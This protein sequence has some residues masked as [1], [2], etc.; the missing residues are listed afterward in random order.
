MF[1]TGKNSAAVETNSNVELFYTSI[2]STYGAKSICS[3]GKV[4]IKA[5][6]SLLEPAMPNTYEIRHQTI[7]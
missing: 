4:A 5:D 1:A 3:N 7:Q 2:T 6:I